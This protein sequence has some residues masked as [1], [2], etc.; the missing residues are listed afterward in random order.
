MYQ[1][2]IIV[3]KKRQKSDKLYCKVIYLK[4]QSPLFSSESCMTNSIVPTRARVGPFYVD[5]QG[6]QVSNVLEEV[7]KRRTPTTR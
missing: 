7:L 3:E 4:R 2:L 1:L 5:F 6:R